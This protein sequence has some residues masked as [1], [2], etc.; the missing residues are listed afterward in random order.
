MGKAGLVAGLLSL[1]G[2]PLFGMRGAHSG[3]E[4]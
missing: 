1:I 4:R 2:I 3:T